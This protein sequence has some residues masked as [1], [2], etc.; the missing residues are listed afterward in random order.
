MEGKK[1]SSY[2]HNSGSA[3][4][5]IREKKEL[6]KVKNNPKQCKL[7]FNLTIEK[8]QNASVSPTTN[9]ITSESSSISLPCSETEPLSK[10]LPNTTTTL[11]FNSKSNSTFISS[12]AK[13]LP[14]KTNILEQLPKIKAFAITSH[15]E[16][17]ILTAPITAV[18]ITN[19]SPLNSP[20][21]KPST[22]SVLQD[23]S[24]V[25]SAK[26]ITPINL[27]LLYS[28]TKCSI[29]DKDQGE[30]DNDSSSSLS[31]DNLFIAPSNTN[32]I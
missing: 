7:N 25:S 20:M 18:S 28:H 11:N 19:S 22:T 4:R 10:L 27:N 21:K 12:P 17:T 30:S 5:K 13:L 26:L 32:T 8:P 23:K 2:Q 9:L 16:S 29:L 24:I 6:E 1:K 15:T 31:S 14:P 3:K